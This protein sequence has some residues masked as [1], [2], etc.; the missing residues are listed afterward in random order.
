MEDNENQNSPP[1]RGEPKKK[2]AYFKKKT[3]VTL[4]N[5]LQKNPHC[6]KRPLRVYEDAS[7]WHLTKLELIENIS[8]IDLIS[9]AIKYSESK[10]YGE[11]G[12]YKRD[13]EDEKR[14]RDLINKQL[15]T[16]SNGSV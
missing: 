12:V 11:G 2:A 14:L 15:K 7:G 9:A 3:A 5:Y 8:L 4:L 13:W 16:Y 6:K 1:L 10:R